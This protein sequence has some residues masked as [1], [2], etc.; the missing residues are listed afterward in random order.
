MR[1]HGFFFHL[2]C[3]KRNPLSSG[4][5]VVYLF[6]RLNCQMG[7]DVSVFIHGIELSDDGLFGEQ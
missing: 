1:L 2:V 3:L 7:F 4:S 6:M 5:V